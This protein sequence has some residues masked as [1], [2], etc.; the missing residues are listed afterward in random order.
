MCFDWST[1]DELWWSTKITWAKW[2][3]VSKLWEF[4]VTSIRIQ[5]S[6]IVFLFARPNFIKE[7][8]HVL[9]G[10]IAWWKPR[11]AFARILRQ[12][13]RL[14]CVSGFHL[15]AL[16]FSQTFALVFTRLWRYREHVLFLIPRRL[17]WF[18]LKIS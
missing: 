18:P 17:K 15:Y 2:L 16:K 13:K 8:K 14:H 4:T 10:F 6:Y 9:R 7:I 5:A 3:A 11:R 1:N 12:A